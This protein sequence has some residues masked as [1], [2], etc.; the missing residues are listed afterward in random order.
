MGWKAQGAYIVVFVWKGF[1]GMG[2]SYIALP[3]GGARREIEG[4]VKERKKGLC[5]YLF[6]FVPASVC[7]CAP[8]FLKG[9]CVS[10]SLDGQLL[11]SLCLL[12]LIRALLRSQRWDHASDDDYSPPNLVTPIDHGGQLNLHHILYLH[13]HVCVITATPTIRNSLFSPFQ[14]PS[15][16]LARHELGREMENSV[17]ILAC[18]QSLFSATYM[19]ILLTNQYICVCLKF[20]VYTKYYEENAVHLP[21]D[22][23]DQMIES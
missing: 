20:I 1:G 5:L 10:Y 15:L 16:F 22:C 18:M 7:G 9:E 6:A 21:F 3:Q 17:F 11:S 12:V 4:V 19:Q 2:G 23:L 8:T 14:F 13:M